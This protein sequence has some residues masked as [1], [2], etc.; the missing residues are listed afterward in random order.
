MNKLRF[1]ELTTKSTL[2][3]RRK[4]NKFLLSL[5]SK[6]G[7]VLDRVDIIF[8]TDEFLYTLNKE[9]LNHDYYTDTISFLLSDLR[10]PLVGEVYI[11]IDRVKDNS[12]QRQEQYKTELIRIII[13][14]ILH[15]C[16]YFDKPKMAALKMYKAQEGY[17]NN[18]LFHVEQSK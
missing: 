15:L 10:D 7:L 9:F 8:C 13:H 12:K 6:E 1:H 2:T 17:L 11:S 14:G 16:G 3:D 18:W 5:F 4:L